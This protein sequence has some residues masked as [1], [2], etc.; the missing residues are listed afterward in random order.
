MSN[1]I[2]YLAHSIKEPLIHSYLQPLIGYQCSGNGLLT[3]PQ[4]IKTNNLSSNNRN[5]MRQQTIWWLIVCTCV[6]SE[7][8]CC[9]CWDGVEGFVGSKQERCVSEHRIG[10]LIRI[11]L[12]CVEIRCRPFLLLRLPLLLNGAQSKQGRLTNIS[13][14]VQGW[15]T[16]KKNRMAIIR[17]K[18]RR[19]SEESLLRILIQS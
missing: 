18:R 2:D 17:R 7:C 8:F 12:D 15:G 6:S 4:G 16:D 1:V 10:H 19:P 9:C 13:H 5:I 14:D 3:L 11:C